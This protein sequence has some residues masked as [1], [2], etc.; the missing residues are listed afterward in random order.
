LAGYRFGSAHPTI[1]N[2]GFADGSV[3]AIR[4]NVELQLF[5]RLAHRHDGEMVDIDSL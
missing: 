5:N 1:M 3:R 4:Y 2:A